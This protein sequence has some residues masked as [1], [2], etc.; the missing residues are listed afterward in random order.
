[1]Y[2]VSTQGV[3]ECMINVH[4]YYYIHICF[5]VSEWGEVIQVPI[6]VQST[7]NRHAFTLDAITVPVLSKCTKTTI[8]IKIN[9]K[10]SGAQT[11]LKHSF[12]S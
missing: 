9:K 6:V 11:A 10:G 7:Q 3:D 1:M 5:Y 2:H 4:Y 12:N 8:K